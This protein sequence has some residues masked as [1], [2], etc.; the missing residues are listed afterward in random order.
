MSFVRGGGGA[1][2]PGVFVR[3]G[4]CPRTAFLHASNVFDL[5]NRYKLLAKLSQRDAQ[6]YILRLLS[7]EYNNECVCV[8]RKSCPVGI[9]VLGLLLT[10]QWC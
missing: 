2:V 10:G 6:K 1:F 9:Y 3:M 7:N 8:R 4:F 5:V